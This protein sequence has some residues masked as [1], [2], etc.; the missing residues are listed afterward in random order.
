MQSLKISILLT[1]CLS[2]SIVA[3]AASFDSA[4]DQTKADLK[5]SLVELAEVRQ[6]V[7]KEKIPLMAALSKLEDEVIRKKAEL[8]R[9]RRLRDN[10]DL[11]LNRLREQVEA[12]QEQNE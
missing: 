9:L 12:I 4:A 10:S 5:A 3:R 1:F 7:T 8:D 2:L 11:G 6:A